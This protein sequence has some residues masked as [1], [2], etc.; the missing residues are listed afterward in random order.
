VPLH[1]LLNFS[2]ARAAEAVNLG[3]EAARAWCDA[4]G[5]IRKK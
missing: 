5:V 3:V 1:Y 2:K 4:N